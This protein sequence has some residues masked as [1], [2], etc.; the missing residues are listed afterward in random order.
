MKTN[1][2]EKVLKKARRLPA[3][4]ACKI[5]TA[6]FWTV[7]QDISAKELLQ[8]FEEKKNSLKTEKE[9]FRLA[10]K[11]YEHYIKTGNGRLLHVI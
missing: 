11:M 8:I 10:W 4:K 9:K 5:V 2:D 7:E 3:I 1:Q 6:N